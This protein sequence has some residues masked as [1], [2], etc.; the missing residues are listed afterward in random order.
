MAK[1]SDLVASQAT[2]G[3]SEAGLASLDVAFPN[4]AGPNFPG[5]DQLLTFI[6]ALGREAS[7]SRP[8]GED[9]GRSLQGQGE[10]GGA[11]A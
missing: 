1:G 3:L 7:P 11:A 6:Q 9:E 5:K 8:G 4:G 10:A 2:V